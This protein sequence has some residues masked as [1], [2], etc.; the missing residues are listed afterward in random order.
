M[1]KRI[2]KISNCLWF[3][4]NA[5]EAVTFYTCVFKNSHIGRISHYTDEGK[6]IHGMA[7]GT[8]MTIEFVLED[9][10]F[11][12]L[13]GGP[14]FKFNEAIS[15]MVYCDTQEEIDYY[16]DKL[17]EGGD[18]KAQQCGW[19]KDKFGV[20]WQIT[21]P[22]LDDMMLDDDKEKVRRVTRAMLQMK[23]LDIAELQRA[24]DGK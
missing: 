16:W 13:N 5:S 2:S 24:F 18:E 14:H 23:K 21:P 3:D 19:L 8:V 17:K 1:N 9:Q 22:V 15:F 7:E 6:E 12:A 4:K 20:S 11:M 10:S